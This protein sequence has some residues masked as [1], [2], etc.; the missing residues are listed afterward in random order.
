MPTPHSRRPLRRCQSLLLALAVVV[1]TGCVNVEYARQA[2]RIEPRDGQ[3]LVFGRIRFFHD[4]H[5]YYPWRPTIVQG[6]ERHL[7]LLRLDRRS[8]SAEM[9]PDADGTL[10]IW[11]TP[12]D[13]ALVGSTEKLRSMSNFRETV[14]LLRVPAGQ[15]AVYAGDLIFTTTTSREGGQFHVSAF[16]SVTVAV[17]PP[18]AAQEAMERRLAALPAPTVS[19]PWCA[20]ADV[21]AFED[22]D[23]VSRARQLLDQGCAAS[24]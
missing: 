21:P 20:G 10:A 5:E 14:A 17:Q 2:Q 8:V 22:P 11:I 1:L 13:Y 9:H 19:S 12:G 18:E 24:R 15:V 7:W 23:L 4:G 3:A 6:Y 16:G